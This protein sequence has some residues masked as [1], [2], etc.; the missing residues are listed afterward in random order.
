MTDGLD[1]D[2]VVDAITASGS[3][4]GSWSIRQGVRRIRQCNGTAKEWKDEARNHTPQFPEDDILLERI[5]P[6]LFFGV[7]AM[8]F[9]VG[10]FRVVDS[11]PILYLPFVIVPV[12]MGIFSYQY[13]KKFSFNLVDEVLD[14]GDA[15]LVRSGG[16]EERIALADITNVNYLPYGNPSQVSLSLR[17]PSVFGDTIVFC[18]P[19]RFMPLSSDPII[20][21]LIHR[22][23][24]ARRGH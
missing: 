7:V 24:A 23:D 19:T 11:D 5:F 12:L 9:L 22:I 14:V 16:R 10:L 13:I 4:C 17:R 2:E 3:V 20:E 15:L 21:K 6:V 8:L 18:G 1:L